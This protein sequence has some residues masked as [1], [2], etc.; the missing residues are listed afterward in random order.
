LHLLY[1]AIVRSL[2]CGSQADVHFSSSLL[3][4]FRVLSVVASRGGTIRYFPLDTQK[5]EVVETFVLF[6]SRHHTVIHMKTP[7][8]SQVFG[9]E[10][11]IRFFFAMS[12][13]GFCFGTRVMIVNSV[14]QQ[15][16]QG[17][18]LLTGYGHN[19]LLGFFAKWFFAYNKSRLILGGWIHYCTF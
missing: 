18:N 15:S 13:I 10:T 2:R 19:L 5:T 4:Y 11:R 7:W 12:Q 14:Y 8:V 16:Q 6:T 1:F 9:G 3:E 17:H